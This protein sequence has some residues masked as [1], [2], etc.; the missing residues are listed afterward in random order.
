MRRPLSP[1]HQ[2]TALGLAVGI[3][4]GVG[5]ATLW[6]ASAGGAP[7]SSTEVAATTTAAT[8]AAPQT[9][10][11]PSSEPKRHWPPAPT[12]AADPARLTLD[13]VK[14][15][16]VKTAPGR[17]VEIDEDDE[18]T[19]LRYDVTVRHSDHTS[20][21]VEVDAATGEV[22]SLDHDDDWD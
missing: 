17:V 7:V 3:G 13:E 21:E 20:T 10:T 22:L 4:V 15:I 16:A 2:F 14:A 6:P 5:A 1:R 11:D 8:P 9:P 18:L 12:A 19:G